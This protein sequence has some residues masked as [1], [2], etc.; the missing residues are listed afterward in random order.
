[1]R[2]TLKTCTAL[3]GALGLLTI[4]ANGQGT[5]NRGQFSNPGQL[6]PAAGPGS[7]ALGTAGGT[8]TSGPQG[9]L[10]PQGPQGPAGPSGTAGHDGLPGAAGAAGAAAAVPLPLSGTIAPSDTFVIQQG[11]TTYTITLPQLLQLL[12]TSPTTPTPTP[13]STP[14]PTPTPTPAPTPTATNTT[15]QIA[16]LAAI[17]LPADTIFALDPAQGVT[18]NATK[19][20]QV[21]SVAGGW[22]FN[23]GGGQTVLNPTGMNGQP[24]FTNPNASGDRALVNAD[25][26]PF[27]AMFSASAQPFS[28]CSVF[29][30]SGLGA[31]GQ[32]AALF[33]VQSDNSNNPKF[34]WS[35]V[36]APGDGS[37]NARLSYDAQESSF[38]D[39]RSAEFS[40]NTPHVGCWSTDGSVAKVAIDGGVPVTGALGGQEGGTPLGAGGGFILMDGFPGSVGLTFTLA[41]DITQDATAYNNFLTVAHDRYGTPSPAQVAAAVDHTLDGQLTS[42]NN[43]SAPLPNNPNAVL[44]D[45]LPTAGF[46]PIIGATF[47]TDAA[48]NVSRAGVETFFSHNYNGATGAIGAPGDTGQSPGG[49]PFFAVAR[50]YTPG[51]VNDLTTVDAT[52]MHIKAICSQNHT[53]CTNGNIWGGF[54]RA[55]IGFKP[56]MTLKARYRSP[57]GDHSWTPT[58]LYEGVGGQQQ[59]VHEIDGNDDFSRFGAGTATGYQVDFGT[60][61]IYGDNSHVGPYLVYTANGGGFNWGGSSPPYS[62]VP[63][64]WSA[65]MHDLVLSWDKKTEILSEF[66]D[67]VLFIQAYLPYQENCSQDSSG[68]CIGLD[69]LLGNQAV[70]TFS[71]NHDGLAEGDGVTG[72]WDSTYREI[73]LFQGALTPEQAKA[74]APPGATNL[75]PSTLASIAP[76]AGQH[77]VTFNNHG[78]IWTPRAANQTIGTQPFVVSAVFA[79]SADDIA[80]G[81]KIMGPWGNYNDEWRF[82]YANN[83]ELLVS[84]QGG[85]P[86][87]APTNYNNVFS[88]AKTNAVANTWYYAEADVDPN[89]GTATFYFNPAGG[90]KTLLGTAAYKTQAN[91]YYPPNAAYSPIPTVFPMNV[92]LVSSS[93]M[94][95]GQGNNDSRQGTPPDGPEDLHGAVQSLYFGINGVQILNPTVSANGTITDNSPG[96]PVWTAM[97]PALGGTAVF[98]GQSTQGST[99]PPA[100][101][102]QAS[103]APTSP[104]PGMTQTL[105]YRPARDGLA[106]LTHG[107]NGTSDQGSSTL[108]QGYASAAAANPAGIWQPRYLPQLSDPRGGSDVPSGNTS[109]NYDPEDAAL[110]GYTPFAIVG[111]NLRIRAQPVSSLSLPADQVPYDPNVQ[112]SKFTWAT[113]ILSSKSRFSQQGGCAQIVA[114][115]P[116][117]TASWPAFYAMPFS[118]THPPERDTI[119]YVSEDPANTYRGNFISNGPVQHAQSIAPGP[120]LSA[121]MHSYTDCMTSTTLTRYFDNVQVGQLDISGLPESQ[122]PFYLLVA[123]QVGSRLSGWVPQPDSTTAATLDLLIQSISAWQFPPS[124]TVTG[125]Q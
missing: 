91:P 12:G 125:V 82:V 101:G 95:S 122:Q 121:G 100:S 6:P 78:S 55:A 68:A 39:T 83:G 27:N 105:D 60:P 8:G 17:G 111:G 113:G 62:T 99:A 18:S 26:A 53:S 98:D 74:F 119:E 31:T 48:A 33:S 85:V 9:P 25:A 40:Y 58:W 32:F 70:P 110:G 109:W 50:H 87:G 61:N 37:N 88:T 90:T 120:D 7:S 36:V 84:W 124:M 97:T 69:L 106:L 75:T 21:A 102:G 49:S 24:A 15:A 11:S 77:S 81:G 14:A 104:V 13:V 3:I 96:N 23:A 112:G 51:S 1:M 79:L 118:E 20:T 29:S 4:P 19:V 46:T 107:G 47:G 86:A 103:I 71:P 35:R 117:S 123:N 80:N 116:H 56:G 41:R 16:A 5:L 28:F 89:A 72:A 2:N 43:A 22:L 64:D 59:K 38:T 76:P 34:V 108:D 93:N 63:F 92:G 42:L 30:V 57:S 115:F 44:G 45:G 67:G 54:N 114:Q 66:A 65:G 52:G 73:D 94:Q 10:G